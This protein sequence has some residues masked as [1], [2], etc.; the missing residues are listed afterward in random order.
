MDF[1]L[2]QL[3]IFLTVVEFKSITKASEK[4]YMTQPAVSIQLKNF[5]T[6]FKMPLVEYVGKQLYVTEYGEEIAI[7]ARKIL[8]QVYNIHY[9]STAYEKLL[10]G[11]IKFS[12]VSTAKYILPYYLT[13]FVKSFPDID[14][15]IDVNNRISVLS[16]ISKK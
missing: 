6:N 1:T 14:I 16:A 12:I 3:E 9:R 8:E 15:K 7:S 4:L 2:H 13:K 5:Q 11:R 10:F